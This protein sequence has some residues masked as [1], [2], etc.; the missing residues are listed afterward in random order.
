MKDYRSITEK[1][2]CGG[3]HKLLTELIVS[4]LGATQRLIE[5]ASA[6]SS[7][8]SQI[9]IICDENTKKYALPIKAS[10]GCEL[11]TFPKNA[12]AN[13]IF[14]ADLG[15]Y[16]DDLP[17]S[18]TLMIACGSGSV[19]DITRFCAY[20]AKIPF[21]SYP[22]AA[23]V[24]GFVSAVAAMTMYG[25]KLTYPSAAPIALFA[26]PDVYSTAPV[27]LTASGA[28]D[29]IGKITALYDWRA[30]ELLCGEA[31]CPEIYGIMEEAL[32]AVIKAAEHHAD[33]RDFAEKVMNGL[34]LSGIA[35]QL[36]GSSRPASGSEHH[37]SHFWEM[38]VINNETSA[39][40]G[41][42][43]G[44][45][46]V[47]ALDFIKN[48]IDLLDRIDDIELSSVFDKDMIREIYGELSD[49]IIKE[50]LP[51]GE[52]SSSV[53]AELVNCKTSALD[54]LKRLTR[55]LPDTEKIRDLLASFGAP[56][57]LSELSLP[58][59]VEF[60]KKSTIFSPYV[61][62]R[63]TVAKIISAITVSERRLGEKS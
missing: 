18:P 27:R 3:A 15:A 42:K 52:T 17:F 50:N 14:T 22:T 38:H 46:T 12:H 24:D 5:Y 56:S 47:L 4:E 11:Y 51:S 28:G 45:G 55:K 57:T 53:I 13:E 43:V 59:D 23:S 9:L 41:E 34:I 31:L 60:V 63:L 39:L 20:K 33:A 35:M 32:D 16:I 62:N 25:Q 6:C 49:G 1:C 54:E 7:D 8:P 48:N 58:D 61:R 37:M 40:H 26:D 19:H 21:V 36:Q 2:S 10:L 44:V 29:V 30:A